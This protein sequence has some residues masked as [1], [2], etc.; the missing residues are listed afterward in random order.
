LL[1]NFTLNGIEELI[2]KELQNFQ[3]VFFRSRLKKSLNNAVTS[4]LFHKFVDN[5]FKERQ[6]SC[7]FCRYAYDFI[8]ICSSSK[9]LSLIKTKLIV[10]LKQRGLVINAQKSRTVLFK[11]NTPFDFLGYTF[12]YLT[13]TKFIKNKMLHKNKPEYRLHGRH[14][15][16]VYPSKTV[17]NSFKTYLKSIIKQNQNLSAYKLIAL[18]NPRIREWVSYYSFSNAH[19]VLSLLRNWLYKRI[20]IWMKRKHPKSSII[21]L[22]KHYFLLNN[23]LKEHNLENNPKIVDYFAKKN[24]IQRQIQRNKWNFYGI[25]R[26]N[27]E[28]SSYKTLQI[29]VMLWTT[30]IKKIVM[31]TTF[32]PNKQLLSYSYYLNQKK[33]I[34]EKKK[35]KR[36]YYK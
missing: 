33:W 1:M 2:N 35:L 30:S 36:L 17:V 31:A 23:L 22:N 26:K 7:R 8:V 16:F 14:K 11:L 20:L 24:F 19:G 12:I 9:L 10:F 34:Q 21:W 15:L 28:G 3:K 4:Y 13:R 27:S 25:V 5:K 18:L 6:I 29:N 32:V